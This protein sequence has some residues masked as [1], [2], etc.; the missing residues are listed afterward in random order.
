MKCTKLK[1]LCP[2]FSLEGCKCTTTVCTFMASPEKLSE[3]LDLVQRDLRFSVQ[4]LWP[5]KE[6]PKIYSYLNRM[7]DA[8]TK[9]ENLLLELT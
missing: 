2:N 9:I 4:G 1:Y 6:D 3:V 7:I 8:K 5:L